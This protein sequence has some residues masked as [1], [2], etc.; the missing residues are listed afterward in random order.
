MPEFEIIDDN[1]A[2]EIL[3]KMPPWIIR[4]GIIVAFG[5]LAG[6][7][8]GSYFIDYPFVISGPAVV[9]YETTRDSTYKYFCHISLKAEKAGMV[10]CGQAVHIRL[11]A[12]PYMQYGQLEG[13]AQAV[14]YDQSSG[15]YHVEVLLPKDLESNYGKKMNTLDHLEGTGR[16]IIKNTTLLERLLH[17]IRKLLKQTQ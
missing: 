6:M 12:Y 5:L 1:E 8:V 2:Q 16:I 17:P 13:V 10:V 14:H 7:L 3:G 4:W 9:S 11:T 15:Q